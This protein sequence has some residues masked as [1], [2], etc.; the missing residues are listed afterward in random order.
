MQTAITDICKA[1]ENGLTV[2]TP[3]RRLAAEWHKHYARYQEKQGRLSYPTPCIMNLTIW[4]NTLFEH[5]ALSGLEQ[6]PSLLN[7][8]LAHYLWES[9]VQSTTDETPLLQPSRTAQLLQSAYTTLKQ[10]Q[11]SLN[12]PA[13]TNSAEDER[14]NQWMQRYHQ[15]C[16]QNTWLDQA[17]LPDWLIKHA[18]R[19]KPYLPK[20]FMLIGFNELTPQQTHFIHCIK[21]H[22]KAIPSP[23][24]GHQAPGQRIALATEKEEWETVA[25]FAKQWQQQHPNARFGMVV[26]DLENKRDRIAHIFKH[27][28]NEA[29]F[30]I[31]A[32]KRLS[33]YPVIQAALQFLNYHHGN[34]NSDEFTILMNTPFL[35]GSEKEQCGRAR[36]DFIRREH[37]IIACH[38]KRLSRQQE[39]WFQEHAPILHKHLTTYYKTIAAYPKQG[40][41]KWGACFN[42]A[43]TCLG[44]PG[45]RILNSEEYQ[46]VQAWLNVLAELSQLDVV[47]GELNFSEALHCLTLITHQT[48]FQAKTPEAPLQILGVL[49]AAGLPFDALW[50]TGLDHLSWPPPAKPNPFIP[51]ALQREKN[52][53]HAT[54]LRELAYCQHMMQQFQAS[55]PTVCFSYAKIKDTTEREASGLIKAFPEITLNDLTLAPLAHTTHTNTPLE[56]LHDETGPA[57]TTTKLSGGINVIK[58]QAH[59]PFKAFAEARLDAQPLNEP[60]P[61]L[62][63]KDRGI[64]LHSALESVWQT[65]QTQ[66]NLMA[67]SD[68]ALDNTLQEAIQLAFNSINLP[69][70]PNSHYLQLEKQRMQTLMKE[71]L[72][73]E[74]QRP[75]FSVL[76]HEKSV[77][78]A[79]GDMT[80]S[81]R[82]DRIDDIGNGKKLIID[83]KT[84]TNNQP[85]AWFDERPDQPQ[86]PLYALLDKNNTA[87][88]TFAEVATGRCKFK[89]VSDDELHMAGITAFA[90]VK[91]EQKQTNFQAQCEHWE[92]SMTTLA[93][94]FANGHAAI[95]PKH[96]TLSCEHCELTAFCRINEKSET[97]AN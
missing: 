1:L 39:S 58:L 38:L 28:F 64:L 93:K 26:Q 53:P 90:D 96:P 42:E 47:A 78:L 80:L 86:L 87:G 79:L 36:L 49:E 31:S 81:A 10:W 88:I 61:G 7:T 5:V 43:L 51:K 2:F 14:A 20:S 89:G 37:N 85:S 97:H 46:V 11:I 15:L 52:M 62:S 18:D 19:L 91:H 68:A 4:M 17:E 9:I 84:G 3:N 70:S 22:A 56:S 67:L 21:Q 8:T 57:L 13:L 50:V 32:G 41:S 27:Y 30:N 71:W 45:E 83:Y 82:I 65:L 40:L 59:C 33:D 34:L 55:A 69:F 48:V 12:D 35:A 60:L 95:D 23:D 94:Q 25:R 76:T 92:I 16:K 24:I 77:S 44:W 66:A 63:A 73:L 54:A 6:T 74:K 75:P 29:D 72:S